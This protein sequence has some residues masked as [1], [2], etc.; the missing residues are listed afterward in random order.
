MDK[1]LRAAASPSPPWADLPAELL[2]DIAGRLHTTADHVRFHAVCRSWSGALAE[3]EHKPLLPWLLAPSWSI[4]AATDLQFEDQLF[5]CVFSKETYR[6]P[7]IC[8]R[9]R[10]VARTTGVPGSLVVTGDGHLKWLR[11]WWDKD[12]LVTAVDRSAAYHKGGFV[13]CVD[14][15]NCHVLQPYSPIPP[16]GNHYY[17]YDTI[18]KTREMRAPLP[19]VPAGKLRRSSYFVERDGGLMLLASVLEDTT[20][21][22]TGDG[23]SVSLHEL[24]GGGVDDPSDATDTGW[25]GDHVLFLGFPVS[26]A[27][28]AATYDGE[29]SGGTA[30]FVIKGVY[31]YSFHDGGARHEL[32][33]LRSVYLPPGCFWICQHPASPEINDRRKS[34]E[35]DGERERGRDG[36]TEE[37]DGES[38]RVGLAHR[39]HRQMG[40]TRT[41]AASRTG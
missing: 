15:A 14:L 38:E 31:R 27:A 3:E 39:Q 8:A 18:K 30:S 36:E 11:V 20:T 28:K 9:D 1:I 37:A 10:L 4:A 25:L 35:S 16:G 22:C 26:F 7:G 23:L 17:Y 13:V 2:G 21:S 34:P 41:V 6:A 40:P 32:S 5:R 29:V 19:D 33:D 24:P 12:D